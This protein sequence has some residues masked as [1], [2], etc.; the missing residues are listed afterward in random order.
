MCKFELS[1][2]IHN[3]FVVS[4]NARIHQFG[5]FS[6]IGAMPK[7]IHSCLLQEAAT[8]CILPIL[9]GNLLGILI[10]MGIIHMVN[11]LLGG[12]GRHEAVFGYHPL[13]L[14]AALLLT[15]ATIWISAWMPAPN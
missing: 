13:V 12:C 14:V 10:S 6:S 5:I 11:G 3:S 15:V 1:I 4:M 2:V 9:I 7:Q 8:L